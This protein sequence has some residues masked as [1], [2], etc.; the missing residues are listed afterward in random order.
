MAVSFLPVERMCLSLVVK[1]TGLAGLFI[2]T[3]EE[4]FDAA[5]DLSE[6]LH[7]I[8]KDHPFHHVLSCAQEIYDDIWTGGKSMYKLEPVV[9]DGGELIIYAPHISK[10]S[11]TQGAVIKKI[12]Y[13]VRD[14]FLKQM[15]KFKGIPYGIMAHST[16]VKGIGTFK[17]G[18]EKPRINVILATQISESTCN[19]I[20]LGYCD[21][22][23][24]DLEKWINREDEGVLF[25]P[26]AG[27]K[28]FRLKNDPFSKNN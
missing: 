23:S 25:V 26:E 19:E 21:P 22:G 18:V 2:G 14:Y 3:P 6:K 7:I 20:N 27:E 8:Y 10:L 9:E 15:D 13:H 16:H 1:E 28:L 5:A 12:G 4:S 17:D 24:I 11:L